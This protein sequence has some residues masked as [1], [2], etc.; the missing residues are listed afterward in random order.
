MEAFTNETYYNILEKCTIES[1]ECIES[2]D[3]YPKDGTKAIWDVSTLTITKGDGLPTDADNEVFRKHYIEDN[4]RVTFLMALDRFW[5]DFEIKYSITRSFF[6]KKCYQ[7]LLFKISQSPLWNKPDFGID[8]NEPCVLTFI[9]N[10]SS[11]IEAR[12]VESQQAKKLP[13]QPESKAEQEKVKIKAPVLALFC[14]LINE[15]GIDKQEETESAT[16]YC[17]RICEKYNL[18]YT[19]RVRQNYYGKKSKENQRELARIVLPLLDAE[20]NTKIQKHLDT[21]QPP[22]QSLYA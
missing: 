19:D 6:Y 14:S 5:K 16:N 12:S 3:L 15:I 11:D 7:S 8:I 9:W 10:M 13:Q 20:T 1:F 21:K 4:M 18:P 17:K 2:I 22:K